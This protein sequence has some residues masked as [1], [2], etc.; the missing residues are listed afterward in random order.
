MRRF[1][2]AWGRAAVD[3]G[4]LT[5][6]LNVF[7]NRTDRS[8]TDVT[9]RINTLPQNTSAIITD[10]I[11]DR[12][13]GEYQGN[14]RMGAFGVA[15]LRGKVRARDREHLCRAVAADGAAADADARRRAR[16]R[17]RASRCGNCRSPIA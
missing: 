15:H 9:Y 5:H 13:G 4:A 17:M 8:F 14:L 7:A 6:N 3:T 2:Q 11:G 10:F 16:Q 1:E 12:I